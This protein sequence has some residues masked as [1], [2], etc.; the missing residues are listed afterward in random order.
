MQIIITLHVGK[1][2]NWHSV[3]AAPFLITNP[4]LT[5]PLELSRGTQTNQ[6]M[7]L[8][9]CEVGK[10]K[11]GRSTHSGL[12]RYHPSDVSWCLHT[13]HFYFNHWIKI[14]AC[15]LL[16]THKHLP[17]NG[18]VATAIV[19]M[20][21]GALDI[22]REKPFSGRANHSMKLFLSVL[23][24]Q[25]LKYSGKSLFLQTSWPVKS[26]QKRADHMPVIPK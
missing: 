19:N 5:L 1:K 20:V 16:A 8:W 18:S 13:F 7:A 3:L 26:A 17:L 22:K 24:Q 15:S 4:N 21:N 25:R 2:E 23:K 6:I 14:I 10:G 9:V 12:P 11:A